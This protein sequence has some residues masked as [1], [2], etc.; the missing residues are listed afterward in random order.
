MTS[1]EAIIAVLL[2]VLYILAMIEIVELL[3]SSLKDLGMSN[4]IKLVFT[5]SIHCANGIIYVPNI[6]SLCFF[7]TGGTKNFSIE[8]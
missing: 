4:N 5:N 7:L 2:F 8:I 6:S 3:T 1:C